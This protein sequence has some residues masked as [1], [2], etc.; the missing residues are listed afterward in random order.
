MSLD[1]L[2]AGD[3]PSR[4]LFGEGRR[5][6][7]GQQPGVSVDGTSVSSAR[8]NWESSGGGCRTQPS[9]QAGQTSAAD[10][11]AGA[12]GVPHISVDLR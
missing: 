2:G 6:G 8:E 12:V 10:G 5:A 3:K 1:K 11:V 4:S 7:A 9:A